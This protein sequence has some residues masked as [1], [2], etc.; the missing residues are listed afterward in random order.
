MSQ[1]EFAAGDP[2]QA[3][4][5]TNETLKLAPLEKRG[6]AKFTGGAHVAIATYRT[7][8]GDLSG[9]RESVGEGLREARRAQ[10]ELSLAF[11]LQHLALL[12]ALG[13]DA[14]RAAQL[15]G[16]VDA[17]CDR[18]GTKRGATDQWVYGKLLATLRDTLSEGEIDEIRGRRGGMVRRSGN[19]GSVESLD[20]ARW[21]RTRGWPTTAR[22][23]HTSARCWRGPGPA[24]SA[25]HLR[26]QRL[27]TRGHRGSES[28]GSQV[29]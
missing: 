17:Q 6:K 22:G 28:G 18:L 16:Y 2:Q 5:L 4:R 7:A 29:L 25:H 26:F 14:Q 15:L 10:E 9:A 24:I 8:L 1:L 20:T 13:G 3:L 11:A 12:A 19:R 23:S 21:I 27:Q